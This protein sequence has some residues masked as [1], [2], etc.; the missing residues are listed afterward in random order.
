MAAIIAAIGLLFFIIVP[1]LA[2]TRQTSLEAVCNNNLKRI[3]QAFHMWAND[4][5]ERLPF[6]VPTSEGGSRG[7][8]TTQAQRHFM[9]LSNEL[10]HPA[11]MKCPADGASIPRSFEDFRSG[12]RYVS[13][14]ITHGRFGLG[15]ELLSGDRNVIGLLSS[16]GPCLYF[17]PRNLPPL[18]AGWDLA[19]HGGMG[20]LL[21]TGGEVEFVAS[22]GFQ[23]LASQNYQTNSDLHVLAP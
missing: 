10:R 19:V 18:T 1:L 11:V 12:S 5:D 22:S 17:F 13:Y 8:T 16:G 7:E 4:H 2:N 6:Y 3:G 9:L 20:H 23:R 21:L 15:S 14:F